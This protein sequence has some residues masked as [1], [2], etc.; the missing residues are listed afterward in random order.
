[1][2]YREISDL[3]TGVNN[4]LTW[5]V[6]GPNGCNH[7]RIT[8]GIFAGAYFRTA[9]RAGNAPRQVVG[10]YHGADGGLYTL[11]GPYDTAVKAKSVFMIRYERN[12]K[13]YGRDERLIVPR[14]SG[15]VDL[16]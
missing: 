8:I 1:M 6:Q 3:A 14:R 9:R 10:S 16:V 2:T 4:P 13:K 12:G 11:G 7:W 15:K 5:L